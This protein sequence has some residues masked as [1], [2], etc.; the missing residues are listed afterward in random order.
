MAIVICFKSSFNSKNFPLLFPQNHCFPYWPADGEPANIGLLLV[1][2]A[3]EEDRQGFVKRD[4]RVTNS[5]V[6][7]FNLIFHDYLSVKIGLDN[8]LIVPRT[9]LIDAT[10]CCNLW[11]ESC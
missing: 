2:I 3:A 10:K 8:G 11:E 6:G 7:C 4:F 9:N 1:Q 5:K